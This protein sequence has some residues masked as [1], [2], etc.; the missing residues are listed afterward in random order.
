[1]FSFKTYLYPVA[2]L[3]AE[4]L[5]PEFADAIEGLAKGNAPGMWTYKAAV[6]WGPA[7]CEFLR[8]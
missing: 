7:V 2:Q 8:S 6:R 1:M 5:G 4:G 3:K